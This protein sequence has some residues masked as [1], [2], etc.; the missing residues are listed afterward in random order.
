MIAVT[1]E[2]IEYLEQHVS[3]PITDDI[4]IQ[5]NEHIEKYRD[6]LNMR[7]D[8]ADICAWYHDE[9]DFLSDWTEIG[10]SK[11]Q[12]MQL[13]KNKVEFQTLKNGIILRY[14]ACHIYRKRP[15]AKWTVI[16]DC[17]DDD[18]NPTCWARRIDGK[19]GRFVWITM[20]NNRF[21]VEVMPYDDVVVL[22]TCTSLAS[23]KRWA[24][25]HVK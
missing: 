10:Y 22:K 7:G 18:G 2:S 24:A 15:A 16:H 8:L 9:E 25:S 13:L 17:D 6:S 4:A 11:K 19:H 5:I 20:H 3:N 21:D 1:R 23:A 14:D 12:A